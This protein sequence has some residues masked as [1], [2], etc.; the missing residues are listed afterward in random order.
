MVSHANF[1]YDFHRGGKAR[2]PVFAVS[3]HIIF[4]TLPLP[5]EAKGLGQ[6]PPTGGVREVKIPKFARVK[7]VPTRDRAINVV[8][9][10][11]PGRDAQRDIHGAT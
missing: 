7:P 4:R 5:T 6:R 3:L 1:H 10:G 8:A 11:R 9:S 2:Q